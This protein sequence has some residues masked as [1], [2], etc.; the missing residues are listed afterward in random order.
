MQV[1]RRSGRSDGTTSVRY[2][3]DKN[4][5]LIG[6]IDS[7]GNLVR[8][9]VY[10]SQSHVP[11]YFVDSSSEKYRIITDHLGSV[12]LVVKESDGT[13]MQ[14]MEHDEFGR[15]VTDTNPGYQPFGFAGGIWDHETGL[16]RF[17]ARDY[18]VMTGRWTSKDPIRFDGKMTN[19]YGYSFVDPV[20]FVDP[21]GRVAA[22]IATGTV[23]AVVG[24]IGAY[25]NSTSC[26]AGGKALDVVIGATMGFAGGAIPGFGFGSGSSLSFGRSLASMLGG[27]MVGMG[28]SFSD[29][30]LP[31]GD[32]ILGNSCNPTPE[33]KPEVQSDSGC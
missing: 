23:G 5:R 8:R 32:S 26:S 4:N 17:G 1:N 6:E 15:I 21:E 12:R 20:N 13:I 25:A 3:H 27:F 29:V 9:Y 18:D 7:L 24:G 14:R 28:S 33:S 22:W 19:L 30:N 31:S 16:V 11:D 2:V 10:A